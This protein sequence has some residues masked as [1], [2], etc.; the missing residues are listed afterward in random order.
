MGT[1][2]WC[3]KLCHN[4]LVSYSLGPNSAHLLYTS[5]A[6]GT[7][8]CDAII[9]RSPSSTITSCCGNASTSGDRRSTG[10]ITWKRHAVFIDTSH[11]QKGEGE[12]ELRR[13]AR[14]PSC[15]YK[16]FLHALTTP[17][18]EEEYH[19]LRKTPVGRPSS[20]SL[21]AN[22]PHPMSQIESKRQPKKYSLSTPDVC[23]NPPRR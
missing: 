10:T 8:L 11:T 5:S 7:V 2:Y 18:K 4:D 23:N 21:S 15:M 20:C 3:I 13:D 1:D 14:N 17:K 12:R 19:I 9:E 22:L 6:A 16:I